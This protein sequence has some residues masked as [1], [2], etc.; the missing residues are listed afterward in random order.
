MS[1]PIPLLDATDPPPFRVAEGSASSPFVIAADH[2][3]RAIPRGL[4]TLGLAASELDTH[5]AWDIGIGAVS[6][7]LAAHLEAFFIAQTYSR[8]VIDC[9]R[10]LSASSSIVQLSEYTTVPGNAHL[11]PAEAEARAAAIFHPYHDR[12]DA[13]IVRR[14]RAGQ[15]TIFIAMHSF[16]PRFKGFDRP[17][18]VGVLYNRDTRLA[19]PLLDL[20]RREGL[21][22]GDNQPYFVSDDTDYAIPRYGEG[23]GNLCIELEIRQ[24]LITADAQQAR[25]GDLLSRVLR[26]AVNVC[27]NGPS[28]IASAASS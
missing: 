12:I 23:R 18:H 24:D 3:G 25:W 28:S 22:V 16:T 27:D 13:E 26:E 14:E 9:N 15:R 21:E 2:A 19:V 17:W 5:I 20:L 10:P 1:D 8:L 11:A 7:H 4:G 6:Q